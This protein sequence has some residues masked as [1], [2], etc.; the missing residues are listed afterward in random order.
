MSYSVSFL[1]LLSPSL[2]LSHTHVH[3]LQ[4]AYI[5]CISCECNF[6]PSLFWDVNPC[7]QAGIKPQEDETDPEASRSSSPPRLTSRKHK[8]NESSSNSSDDSEGSS[9]APDMDFHFPERHKPTAAEW[10]GAEESL[11]RVLADMCRNDYCTQS[12]LI[13]SKSC[14]QVI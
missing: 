4:C 9:D 5:Q 11:F 3:T 1:I 10:S 7:T 13:S 12:K 14:K 8:H 2:S 6:L